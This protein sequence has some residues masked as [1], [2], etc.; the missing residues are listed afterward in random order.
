MAAPRLLKRPPFGTPVFPSK[1]P[2]PHDDQR[3]ATPSC[4]LAAAASPA[5]QLL[6]RWEAL[7]PTERL[8]VAR[9]VVP[10][11]DRDPWT[12]VADHD[13]CRCGTCTDDTELL[14]LAVLARSTAVL[15][16]LPPRRV[17]SFLQRLGA[18]ADNGYTARLV[19]RVVNTL[20]FFGQRLAASPQL[21]DLVLDALVAAPRRN[22]ISTNVE[23]LYVACLYTAHANAHPIPHARFLE[24]DSVALR[25][26]LYLLNTY[27]H[28]V[29]VVHAALVLFYDL[30]SPDTPVATD[31]RATLARLGVVDAVAAVLTK[32]RDDEPCTV[33]ALRVLRN[34]VYRNNDV[35][36]QVTRKIGLGTLADLVAAAPTVP[37]APDLT[38]AALCALRNIVA[39]D[40]EELTGPATSCCVAAVLQHIRPD[41]PPPVAR[42]ALEVLR[43]ICLRNPDSVA[44]LLAPAALHDLVALLRRNAHDLTMHHLALAL[45]HLLSI[46]H[47]NEA[48]A[49]QKTRR[50]AAL[51]D[52]GVLEPINLLAK[53]RDIDNDTA[54][55]CIATLVHIATTSPA[56]RSHFRRER[57]DATFRLLFQRMDFPANANAWAGFLENVFADIP[58][59]TCVPLV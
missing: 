14:A 11:L 36:A 44:L 26:A 7:L 18:P 10:T 58:G 5:Y 2:A 22:S 17:N 30:T 57:V 56:A 13:A 37:A 40:A 31:I 15:E 28:C 34:V 54:I 47:T 12:P 39:C 29:R 35:A 42:C 46:V 6:P 9:A 59:W 51:L 48:A 32:S 8:A 49:P 45:T 21:H 50:A 43:N 3:A 1:R 52:A 38:I 4:P 33:F 16:E 24:D 41:T 25:A 20:A 19:I 55:H 27:S 53:R 23:T